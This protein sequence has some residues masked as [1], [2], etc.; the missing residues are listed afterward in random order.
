MYTRIDSLLPDHKVLILL[1][2]VSGGY[3]MMIPHDEIFSVF[4]F[5]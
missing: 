5:L 4:A 3:F 1:Y 2:R